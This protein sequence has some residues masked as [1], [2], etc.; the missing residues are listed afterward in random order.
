MVWR[1]LFSIAWHDWES[2][3]RKPQH[4]YEGNLYISE[5]P[6]PG[7]YRGSISKAHITLGWCRILLIIFSSGLEPSVGILLCITHNCVNNMMLEQGIM[8]PG[9]VGWFY[10]VRDYCAWLGASKAHLQSGV[11]QLCFVVLENTLWR[12]WDMTRS[13]FIKGSWDFYLLQNH[14][15]TQN[16]WRVLPFP[17]EK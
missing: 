4:P 11:S 2:V 13:M 1:C 17:R 6:S 7:R 5:S 9:S 10:L 8:C 12:I 16:S 14:T 15:H 3:G